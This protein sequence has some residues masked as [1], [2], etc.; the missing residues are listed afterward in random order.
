[1]E[2]ISLDFIGLKIPRDYRGQMEDKIIIWADKYIS[3][4]LF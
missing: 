1:M 2:S 3:F 4:P